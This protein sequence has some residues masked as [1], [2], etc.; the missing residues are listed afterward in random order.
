[1]TTQSHSELKIVGSVEV[2]LVSP[3]PRSAG[4]AKSDHRLDF[5]L[6]ST[7]PVADC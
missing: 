3:T 5:G 7:K 6:N 1:M 2:T 4:L